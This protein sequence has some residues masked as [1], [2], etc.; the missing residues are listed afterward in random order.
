MHKTY[1]HKLA[2]NPSDEELE[3]WYEEFLLPLFGIDTKVTWLSHTQTDPDNYVHAF[4]A[5]DRAYALAFDD[6]PSGFSDLQKPNGFTKVMRT[7]ENTTMLHLESPHDP[8]SVNAY[9]YFMLFEITDQGEFDT[10]MNYLHGTYT[11]WH[12]QSSDEVQTTFVARDILELAETASFNKDSSALYRIGS[13]I[14]AFIEH[15]IE[16][17]TVEMKLLKEY[18]HILEDA[19]Y[20]YEVTSPEQ[21][22]AVGDKLYEALS[23]ESQFAV[24]KVKYAAEDPG[25]IAT[26]VT[27]AYARKEKG[28][29]NGVT[30]AFVMQEKDIAFPLPDGILV[31]S[32][33]KYFAENDFIQESNIEH[34]LPNTLGDYTLVEGTP[35]IR[36]IFLRELPYIYF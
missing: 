15:G 23:K 33:K 30:A 27:A 34:H 26:L 5:G 32:L 16:D 4:R 1:P 31:P 9:G 28:V 13:I 20:G 24:A 2:Y 17:G 25:T 10:R 36:R 7:I 3:S 8:Y 18:V 35:E 21:R 14:D 29:T 12:N 6:Y 19:E 22:K 11:E